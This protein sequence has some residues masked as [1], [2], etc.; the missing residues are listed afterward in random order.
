M[1]GFTP[2]EDG[3]EA[4]GEDGCEGE[5]AGEDAPALPSS[6]VEGEAA[7]EL[8]A[9]GEDGAAGAAPDFWGPQPVAASATA[10]ARPNVRIMTLW[11]CIAVP[12]SSTSCN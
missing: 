1:I 2:G 5:A 6:G 10:A 8:P 12:R 3:A 7:G 4:E 11:R 9:T